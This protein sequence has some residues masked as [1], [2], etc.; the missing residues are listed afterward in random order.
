M[1][2]STHKR[3]EGFS[4]TEL[5]VVLTLMG[6]LFAASYGGILT[7]FKGREVSDRQAYFAREVSTPLLIAE[8]I[9]SQAITI[10]DAGD[11]TLTVL[12]DRDND[13]V[14]E[15]H[16]FTVDAQGRFIE[17]IWMTDS[18]RDNTALLDRN[19]WSTNIVNVA[20]SQSL[21]YYYDG[22]LTRIDD[23]SLVSDEVKSVDV[24]IAVE[25]DGEV[26]RGTRTV[27][28]RNR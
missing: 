16:I 18:T 11:Y 20:K 12:T 24:N 9:L 4:L 13:K 19:V 1:V 14:M 27:F 2:T 26:F 25:Y 8:K 15:R 17:E 10:E 21:F 5:L 28:F 23:V 22:D 3:Q 6:V 7:T